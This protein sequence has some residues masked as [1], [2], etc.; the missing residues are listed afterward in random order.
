VY[1]IHIADED[2]TRLRILPTLKPL[3]EIP[4]VIHTANHTSN[5]PKLA[6]LHQWR[7]TEQIPHCNHTQIDRREES[8]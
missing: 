7:G 5:F 2:I 4:A 8:S 6:S 1:R 3:A